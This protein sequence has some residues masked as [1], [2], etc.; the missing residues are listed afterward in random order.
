MFLTDLRIHSQ[1]DPRVFAK[2]LEALSLLCEF[3][4]P[5]PSSSDVQS[6]Q[7]PFKDQTEF[8]I[9]AYWQNVSHELI[10]KR[11]YNL[12]VAC[13]VSN[14]SGWERDEF[15]LDLLRPTYKE[16]H[17]GVHIGDERVRGPLSPSIEAE[18]ADQ[19][20]H[21]TNFVPQFADFDFQANLDAA[22][23]SSWYK[24]VMDVVSESM[25]AYGEEDGFQLFLTLSRLSFK[26]AYSTKDRTTSIDFLKLGLSVVL[27][28]VSTSASGMQWLYLARC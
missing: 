6:E 10:S 18:L 11:V 9:K 27:P 8:P 4:I 26:A 12:A 13:L 24:E 1:V 14:F 25:A 21:I 17:F 7:D 15:H 23:S 5:D 19:W 16:S 3:V 22:K 2:L 28:L 20:K